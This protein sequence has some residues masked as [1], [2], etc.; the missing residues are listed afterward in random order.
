M[1]QGLQIC[2]NALATPEMHRFLGKAW[3]KRFLMLGERAHMVHTMADVQMR[4]I[5]H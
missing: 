1:D 2:L 3:T 5:I 4:N